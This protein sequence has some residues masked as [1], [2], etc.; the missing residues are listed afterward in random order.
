MFKPPILHALEM[1]EHE[2]RMEATTRQNHYNY[3]KIDEPT[4]TFI[5]ICKN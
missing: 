4:G 1:R 3:Q 2:G 5:G